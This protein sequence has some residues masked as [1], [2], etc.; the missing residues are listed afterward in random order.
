MAGM[1]PPEAGK[2]PHKGVSW[3]W[4]NIAYGSTDTAEKRANIFVADKL[5]NVIT[6]GM[7]SADLKVPEVRH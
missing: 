4:M 3:V 2:N 5:V 1:V 7:L 6:Q